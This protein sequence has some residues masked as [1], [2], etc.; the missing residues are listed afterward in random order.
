MIDVSGFTELEV[1]TIVEHRWWS[2]AEPAAA[3]D[4]VVYPARLAELLPD[5]GAA[6]RPVL[7]LDDR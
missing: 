6:D 7:Q 1:R 2:A 4:E 3:A 5:V